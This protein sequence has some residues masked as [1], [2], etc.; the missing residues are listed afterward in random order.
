MNIL[1]NLKRAEIVARRRKNSKLGSVS[2][3]I[4]KILE[5][6]V[7]ILIDPACQLYQSAR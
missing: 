1:N 6:L 2:V 5:V 4:A 7:D 3:A